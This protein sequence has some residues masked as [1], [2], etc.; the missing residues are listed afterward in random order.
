MFC[1]SFSAKNCFRLKGKDIA[2]ENGT[3]VQNVTGL[4]A[5]K[6][7]CSEDPKCLGFDYNNS[8]ADKDEKMCWTFSKI[9]EPITIIGFY[10]YIKVACEKNSADI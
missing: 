3:K 2:T 10:Q 1:F 9:S 6:S 8:R 7:V 4:E 5:C